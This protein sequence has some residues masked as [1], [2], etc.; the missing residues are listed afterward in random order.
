LNL[1][2]VTKNPVTTMHSSVLPFG[3]SLSGK[4]IWGTV[5]VKKWKLNL[6]HVTKNPVTTM[7]SS[8]LPFGDSLSNRIAID[9][10]EDRAVPRRIY[11]ADGKAI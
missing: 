2:H 6:V 3:D 11:Q 8:V 7:H 5:T 10:L 9:S 4:A 1:V